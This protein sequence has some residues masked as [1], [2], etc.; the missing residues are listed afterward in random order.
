MTKG[1]ILS[2]GWGTRLRP[3]TCT[4]PKTLIPVVNKPVIE[5]QIL[6]LKSVGVEEIVLAVS[7]MADDIKRYF[8]DGEDLGVIIHYTDEKQ[9]MG[10]A[11]ALKL[12]EHYLHDDRFFMLNG[13]EIINFDFHEMLDLHEKSEAFGTIASMSV[14]DPSSY[15][16]LIVSKDSE[17]ILKF[18]EKEDYTPPEGKPIP[19]PVNVGVY[20]LE[21]EIFSVIEP[22]KKLSIEKDIFPQIAQNQKLYHYSI[23]GIWRDIGKPY[24]LLEGNILLMNRLIQQSKVKKENLIAD[25]VQFAENV[26]IIPPVTIG[27]HVILRD[28]CKIGPNVVIGDNVNVEKNAEIKKAV[29][30]KESYIGENSKIEKAIVSNNCR[31]QEGVVLK[32][33][34]EA[35]VILASYVEVLKDV[36]LITPDERHIT[37]CHHEV[38]RNNLK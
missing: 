37:Y 34:E 2:G 6:L 18:Q 31:I 11:G 8:K 7:V 3:L 10:T 13:D 20:L 28:G 27:E 33:N 5:R 36:Q 4:I 30:F 29:I 15:G 16:V 1:I 19:M 22:N 32:G 23:N 38:V 14:E 35:L 25:N 12:A 26:T 24:D 21:P 17:R 9:P